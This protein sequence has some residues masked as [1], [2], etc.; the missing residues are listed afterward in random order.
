MP[1]PTVF[2][3]YVGTGNAGMNTVRINADLLEQA[4]SL[5]K[6]DVQ[7]MTWL[8]RWSTA[9]PSYNS[10]PLA[11][12]HERCQPCNFGKVVLQN[13]AS[14]CKGRSGT[15]RTRTNLQRGNQVSQHGM[16]VARQ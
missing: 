7:E 9:D 3:L 11:T 12:H 15:V 13:T 10:L 1:K 8:Q 6:H 4:L 16:N 14:G 5:V 2:E